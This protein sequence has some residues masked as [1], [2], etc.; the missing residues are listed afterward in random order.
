MALGHPLANAVD[1][2]A[3][4]ASE[5]C[6]TIA[7]HKFFHADNALFADQGRVFCQTRCEE[8]HSVSAT[9]WRTVLEACG[10]VLFA[11]LR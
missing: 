8:M 11:F 5:A 10:N 4:H 1:M 2:E 7:C 3:A 6:N 9:W